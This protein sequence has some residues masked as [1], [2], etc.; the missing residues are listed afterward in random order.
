LQIY[1]LFI[2]SGFNELS[3]QLLWTVTLILLALTLFLFA[4]SL[5]VRS[6]YR[7]QEKKVEQLKEKLYPLILHYVH[8]EI[9][10]KDIKSEFT[11]EGLEYEVF[12]DII[13]EMLESVRGPESEKLRRL[14]QL[15]PIFKHHY[16]QLKSRKTANRIKGCHYFSYLQLDNKQVITKLSAFLSASDSMLV[17]SAASALMA[18]SKV[19]VRGRALSAIAERP[20]FSTMALLE[21]T[22]K[23]P[24][25]HEDQQDEE[26]ATL[27]E[28]IL[29][30][31]MPH[32]SLGVLIKGTSELGYQDLVKVFQKKLH[33][34]SKR[35]KNYKVL[36][37]LIKA[38]GVFLNTKAISEVKKYRKH[39]HPEVRQAVAE[40][41][42]MLG[43]E[44]NL[45]IVQ[46]LLQDNNF[47]VKLAAIK[48]LQ[49]NDEEGQRVLAESM[50]K[51]AIIES[52]VEMPFN[53]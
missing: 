8:D 35:W 1:N 16:K 13:F 12:E 3:V 43:G 25:S 18:S 17:F 34:N 14:L 38:Q 19:E 24:N 6:R 26:A 42:G 28:I 45:L 37:A 11:G 5:I 27:K 32:K 4:S 50:N 51:H 15:D 49:E 46:S 2:Q 40:A 52:A 30:Q 41:L 7:S 36:Q 20:N 23:F 31:T 48:A 9:T 47:E 44:E 53:N 29:N 21:M 33:A 22:Y 39:T 10:V